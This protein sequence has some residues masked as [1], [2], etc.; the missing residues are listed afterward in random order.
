MCSHLSIRDRW[1]I[2]SLRY[3]QGMPSN[4]IASVIN[5][6][7]QTVYYILQLFR[8]TNDIFE[9]EGRVRTLLNETELPIK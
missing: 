7:I 4:E 8:E 6:S 3:D 2:I 1:R 5:C 9:R